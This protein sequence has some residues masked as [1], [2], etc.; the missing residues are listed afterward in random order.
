M[1]VSLAAL[2]LAQISIPIGPRPRQ[3]ERPRAP[4][5]E[6]GPLWAAECGTSTEWDQP[7]PPV[8]I[9]GNTY[10]VGTCGISAILI[11]GAEGHA[12]ID[13]GTERGADRVA[14]NIRSLGFRLADIRF[15]THSH[16]HLDHVGGIA[17]L[18]QLTG[19]RL[20][21]SAPAARVFA[22]GTNG[23]DDPQ[24]GQLKPFPA[25]AVGRI[26]GDGD[27][28][29]LRDIQLTA[30]A[31]PGHTPGALSWQWE[32]CDGGVCRTMVYADSL[33]P[34]SG[35]AYK[36]SARPAALAAYRA[37]IA[38]IA[39]IRCEILMTP[40]PSAS[41]MKERMTGQQPLFDESGCK[42]YAERLTK[43][44]DERLAK[45]AAAR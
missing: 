2:L 35:P 38:R 17:R 33:S 36:F 43:A 7:A 6:T 23:V 29:R 34:V 16:E 4:I 1:S 24:S 45:E 20:V 22:T 13:G 28:I 14:A 37:S 25:A 3:V 40:H 30:I 44:L 42:A 8:R 21:A 41:A 15:I 11:A 31:T 27:V 5:E 26:I 32:S 39:S 10:L 19:A 18:L 12:L 9:H